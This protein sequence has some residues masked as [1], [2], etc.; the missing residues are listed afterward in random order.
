MNYI[1]CGRGGGEGGGE[2]VL[3]ESLEEE[4]EK[5]DEGYV[6]ERPPL[7]Q[8]LNP[9]VSFPSSS[10]MV[11]SPAEPAHLNRRRKKIQELHC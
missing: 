6:P 11:V 8:S 9:S 1:S 2:S 4:T 7:L 5:E 3:S 10:H